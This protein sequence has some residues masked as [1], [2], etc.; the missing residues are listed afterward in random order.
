MTTEIE[1]AAWE[2]PACG[3]KPR[4]EAE[5]RRHEEGVDDRH[6]EC[7]HQDIEAIN[8]RA[9]RGRGGQPVPHTFMGMPWG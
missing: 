3:Y 7:A 4:S 5:R 8:T 9:R 2:C 6:L 1:L